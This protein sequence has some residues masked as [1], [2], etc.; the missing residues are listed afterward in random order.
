MMYVLCDMC[1]RRLVDRSPRSSDNDGPPPQEEDVRR[2]AE[3]AESVWWEASDG[4]FG[5][6]VACTMMG[7]RLHLLARVGLHEI[8]SGGVF[9]RLPPLI[10]H[11]GPCAPTP[12]TRKRPCPEPFFPRTWSVRGARAAGRWV[13]LLQPVCADGTV[14]SAPLLR[15]D[16][17][18]PP[19]IAWIWLSGVSWGGR[20][21]E[22]EWPVRRRLLSASL[23]G[24]L[25][26]WLVHDSTRA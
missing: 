16:E 5:A 9:L 4:L 6:G 26:T 17:S 24:R 3:C 15:P 8:D 14:L 25:P 2:A 1:R 12:R 13:L 22:D 11:A 21:D 19:R 10:S 18:G 20:G 23:T 7:C